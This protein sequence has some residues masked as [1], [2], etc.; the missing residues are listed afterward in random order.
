MSTGR[1]LAGQRETGSMLGSIL[2]AAGLVRRIDLYRV[3]SEMWDCA[4]VDLT[5]DPID[6]ALLKGVDPRRL[7]VELWF[8][9]R[10][11]L[12]RSDRRRHRVAPDAEAAADDRGDPRRTGRPGGD[13]RMGHP[14]RRRPVLRRRDAR[15]GRPRPV[16]PRPRPLRVPGAQPSQRIAFVVILAGLV[17]ALVLAPIGTAVVLSAAAGI[18][19]LVSVVFKFV[20]A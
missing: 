19:F 11:E 17:A 20:T 1:W 5:A 16:A 4:F 10:V 2:V 6:P 12:R 3:L 9:V 18:G 13:E 8:P 14:P 7:C 15:G